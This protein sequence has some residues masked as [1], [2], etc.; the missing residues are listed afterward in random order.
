MKYR[1]RLPQLDADLFLT[2]GG[3]ETVL[4]FHE[5]LELPSFA[6][7][8]LLKDEKGTEAL[9]KYYEP[10]ASLAREHGVGFV[11]EAPTWRASPRWAS[12]LGYCKEQLVDFN[13]RAIALMEDVRAAHETDST[14]VVLSGCIGPH[15]DGY[16]PS[17]LLSVQA[18]EDYHSTQIETFAGTAA[19]MVTAITMTYAE[20]AIGITRAAQ[21]FDMP[22]AISFTVETDGRLPSGEALGDAIEQVDDETGAGPAYYMINC[23]HPTHFE[24][25][26]ADEPWMERIRG[27][28]ANAS[29]RSHAELDEAEELDEGDPQDL[30]QRYAALANRLPRLTVLG[31]CCGTDHRHVGAIAGAWPVRA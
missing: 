1:D 18:A 25:V 20:E 3:I 19:D 9:R 14:P 23:A 8:D 12:E 30:G 6:A 24:H 4:I 21:K 27:L 16:N 7:F 10:Y 28:R 31:G 13:R 11:A 17:E 2:D 26:L 15:D 22:V 5:G 29:T